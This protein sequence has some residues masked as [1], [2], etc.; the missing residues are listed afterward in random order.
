MS[1][2]RGDGRRWWPIQSSLTGHPRHVAVDT[3]SATD[4][5]TV[6]YPAGGVLYNVN[7]IQR[8]YGMAFAVT[9]QLVNAEPDEGAR[10]WLREAMERVNDLPSHTRRRPRAQIFHDIEPE[11]L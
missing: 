7:Y 6:H 1:F 8:T 3:G 4:A 2:E 9:N 10:D 5:T 11:D